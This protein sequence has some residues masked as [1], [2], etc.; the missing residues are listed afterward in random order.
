MALKNKFIIIRK[1]LGHN[2]LNFQKSIT[3][4]NTKYCDNT[5]T[6]IYIYVYIWLDI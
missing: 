2:K 5:H 3:Y 4:L 1:L 6:P